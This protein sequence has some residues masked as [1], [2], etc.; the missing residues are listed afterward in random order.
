MGVLRA[1]WIR[2]GKRRV[3]RV[4]VLGLPILLAFLF[5]TDYQG[6]RVNVPPFDEQ[7]FRDEQTVSGVL[8][9]IPSNERDAVLQ[10]LVD[11][12]RAGVARQREQVELSEARYAFP[13]SVL[14]ALG[15]ANFVFLATI[16]LSALTTGDDLR[17]GTI[18]TTLLAI[19]DRKRLLAGRLVAL[20]AIAVLLMAALLLLGLI[21]PLVIL[22]AAPVPAVPP[23]DTPALVALLGADVL[24]CFEAIGFGVFAALLWRSPSL[25]LVIALL[26]VAVESATVLYLGRVTAFAQAGP[27]TGILDLLPGRAV[28]AVEERAAA[29]AGAIAR[30]PGE[31]MVRD[32]HTAIAP[33]VAVGVWTAAFVLFAFRRFARMD[34]L[35]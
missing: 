23:I 9:Q 33:I 20:A 35:E 11:Q 28:L 3:T 32:L 24:A 18:R 1:E 30:V 25:P 7:Q 12:Q 26:Y 14:T 21:L 17:G 5:L 31:V 22:G 13:Q 29:A 34:I 2:L 27:L 16:L 15:G 6:S 4:V 19:S 10:Q 8:D